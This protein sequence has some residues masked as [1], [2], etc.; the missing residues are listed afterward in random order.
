MDISIFLKKSDICFLYHFYT[1]KNILI[2]AKFKL[3]KSDKYK[4]G[5]YIY[6]SRFAYL[7]CG[8]YYCKQGVILNL[9]AKTNRNIKKQ[10][11]LNL[12]KSKQTDI[13]QKPFKIL[14]KKSLYE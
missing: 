12:G 7:S 14:L 1:F 9:K 2:F 5:E 13:I 4:N 10:F 3:K 6:L 8:V 11:L